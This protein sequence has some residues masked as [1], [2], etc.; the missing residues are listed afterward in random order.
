[1]K[2][3]WWCVTAW[4]VA[5]VGWTAD[6]PPGMVLVPAG[7]FL[8]GTDEGV[9]DETPRHRREVPAFYIDLYEVTNADYAAFVKATGH[10]P[11][12]LPVE[13]EGQ[14]DW[15][16]GAV[17]D[18]REQF[19]VTGVDWQDAA[20]YAAWAGKRLPTEAEWEKAARGGDGRTYP[21]GNAWDET[22]CNFIT[23]GPT[24]VGSFPEGRSPYGCF[25]MAGNVWEWTATAYL[26]YPGNKQRDNANYGQQYRVVRG[27]SWNDHCRYGVRCYARGYGDPQNRLPALGFRCAMSVKR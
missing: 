17:V 27:G 4:L 26:R 9:G 8:M 6:A 2:V 21:W 7:P 23:D 1:M 10:R 13:A 14:V 25:D 16:N 22:R 19:P 20:A 18:G 3:M 5:C 15:L 12:S 24:E 11:P